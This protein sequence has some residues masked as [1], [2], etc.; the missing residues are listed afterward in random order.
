MKRRASVVCICI[1]C[2]LSLCLS[3]C[4]FYNGN[5]EIYEADGVEYLLSGYVKRCF[6]SE[7]TIPEGVTEH[8]VTLP[9]RLESGHKVEGIGGYVGT[10]VPTPCDIVIEG[11]STENF[12]SREEYLD[13]LEQNEFIEYTLTVNI[14]KYVDGVMLFDTYDVCYI[15]VFDTDNTSEEG[16]EQKPAQYIRLSIYYNIDEDNPYMYSSDGKIFYRETESAQ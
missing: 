1:L 13:M 11:I 14:G 7:I 4:T 10:G 3:S 5:T 8:T 6:V 12:V 9:D 2:L 16:A 15:K